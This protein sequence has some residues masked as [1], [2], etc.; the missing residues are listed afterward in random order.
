MTQHLLKF[1]DS[2]RLSLRGGRGGEGS[3]ARRRFGNN[4]VNLGGD[5]GDGGDIYLEADSNIFDLSKFV[6]KQTFI[7]EN[8]RPGSSNKK[9]G[10]SGKN[11]VLKVPVGTLIKDNNKDEISDLASPGQNCLVVKGGQGGRGNFKRAKTLPAKEGQ[12]K[13]IVLDFYI[14]ADVVIIGFTNAGKSTLMS[15]I[16]NVKPKISQFPFTTKMPLWGVVKKDYKVFTIL[17]LPAIIGKKNEQA[18]G[19]KFLKH[20]KR[21]KILLFLI[22]A[23]D[24]PSLQ[25][26]G[27]SKV[28]SE[29]RI[30]TSSKYSL[31]VLNKIDKINKNAGKDSLKIS[32]KYNVGIEELISRILSFLQR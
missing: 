32:A 19:V 25:I 10:K 9:K 5:G 24:E 8:G 20:T 3:S 1:T 23:E 16:T 28:L 26:E 31:I 7:A 12:L 21:A 22:S 2:V 17:E 6:S 4:F 30:D 27:L 13:K 14:P 18:Y 15:R 11:L 29:N